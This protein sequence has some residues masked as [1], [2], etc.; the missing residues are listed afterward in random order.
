MKTFAGHLPPSKTTKEQQH[1]LPEST[2]TLLGNERMG[3]FFFFA[4]LAL[5]MERSPDELGRWLRFISLA[6]SLTWFFP[7]HESCG[8][9]SSEVCST[10]GFSFS[11]DKILQLRA[12]VDGFWGEYCHEIM[13]YWGNS[14]LHTFAPI[15]QPNVE[16][17][18]DTCRQSWP[19]RR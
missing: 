9:P 3:Q 8:I 10:D 11:N 4:P 18:V 13:Q 1:L 12:V 7:Y 6:L 19:P 5:E 15:W 16:I 2:P 14:P 17:D